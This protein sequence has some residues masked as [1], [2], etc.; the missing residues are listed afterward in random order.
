MALVGK[1]Q[2]L[3]N[4]GLLAFWF[5]HAI[6]FPFSSNPTVHCFIA[7]M[8]LSGRPSHLPATKAEQS[9][10]GGVTCVQESGFPTKDLSVTWLQIISPKAFI[11]WQLQREADIS[12]VP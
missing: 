9:D 6:V 2:L 1:L 4:T 11:D 5:R 7:K 3:A 8:H 10:A 12:T